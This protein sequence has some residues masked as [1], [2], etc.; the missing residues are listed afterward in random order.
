[1]TS[2]TEVRIEW[3]WLP[4]PT[5]RA[6]ELRATW[7]RLE[8]HVASE[9]VTLV[10][11]HESR[12][13]RRAIYCP[14]YPLAEWIAYNWWFLRADSRPASAAAHPS[15]PRL[16]TRQYHR[17]NVRGAGD[18]F[19]WPNLLV[20][21]QGVTT[22]FT[23]QADPATDQAPIRFLSSG[24]AIIDT[25]R[26]VLKLTEFVESVLARLREVG[27][28]ETPLASEWQAIQET[29]E[30][31]VAFCLAAA[32]LGLD[33]YG[34]A[35]VYEDDILHA[36][37]VLGSD[38]FGDFVDAVEPTDINLGLEW[39]NSARQAIQVLTAS[40]TT[41][42][43]ALHADDDRTAWSR[44]RPWEL[45]WERAR[46]VRNAI[47]ISSGVPLN[48]ENTL[49]VTTRPNQG[50]GFQAFGS[51]DADTGP[52][53]V[54]SRHSRDTA[55]RFVLA[56]AMWH[57]IWGESRDFLVTSAYTD[58]QKIE[59]AFAAELLAPAAGV[60]ERISAYPSTDDL[61]EIEETAD[62]FRVS[63]MIIEHQIRN[64]LADAW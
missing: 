55:R 54:L 38:L 32:R 8:I 42:L 48:I 61:D 9:C 17:H 6:P 64:Q 19:L 24:Q 41:A 34:E 47:G 13:A 12:S 51:R 43:P 50:R 44:P 39:I 57:I 62:H 21:P 15:G 30:D 53:V 31:E 7:A 35:K 18:G 45:G 56:R 37:T 59:R 25:D 16:E 49:A 22:Q 63:P 40:P 28:N 60:A 2:S 36:A 20:V 10:E 33:P 29:D 11:D 46:Q 5:I 52:S 23:W 4:A 58:K 27:L 3:E 1:V 26:A 14:L